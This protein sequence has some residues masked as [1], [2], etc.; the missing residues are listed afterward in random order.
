MFYNFLN[1]YFPYLISAL[2]F[3]TLGYF[4]HLFTL[5]EKHKL[6]NNIQKIDCPSLNKSSENNHITHTKKTMA[7]NSPSKSYKKKALQYTVDNSD[8]VELTAKIN[9]FFPNSDVNEHIDDIRMFANRLVSEIDPNNSDVH[10][11]SIA[12]ISFSLTKELPST[13]SNS[14]D[15]SS[16]QVIY[17]HINVN[18][19]LG[20]N[21]KKFFVK[22][23][24]LDT[25][26]ILLFS[27]K[28]INSNSDANW[29][30][31][32]PER[33]WGDKNYEVIFYDYTSQLNKLASETYTTYVNK[34]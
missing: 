14:F 18:G 1:K 31:L 34:E 28:R 8:D 30:S 13:M 26:E 29:V 25:N 6:L 27:P 5:P 22:W 16:K 3:T 10:E 7:E 4:L 15:V 32:V 9:S 11:D 20:A 17:A 33:S 24:N 12:N 23:R 21:S 19:G 2:C